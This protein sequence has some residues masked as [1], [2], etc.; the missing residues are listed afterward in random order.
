MLNAP[1]NRIRT[2]GGTEVPKIGDD[3]NIAEE[4]INI[5]KKLNSQSVSSFKWSP[6]S[7]VGS[8]AS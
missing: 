7:R 1:Q 2:L 5:M 3:K 6:S 4:R 8:K